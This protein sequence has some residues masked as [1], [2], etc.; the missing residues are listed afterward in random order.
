MKKIFTIALL[1]VSGLL[2]GQMGD[3]FFTK[4]TFLQLDSVTF[5]ETECLTMDSV[6][7][8]NVVLRDSFLI[9]KYYEFETLIYSGGFEIALNSVWTADFSDAEFV[10][11]SQFANNIFVCFLYCPK[12]NHIAKLVIANTLNQQCLIFTE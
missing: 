10:S 11:Y 6:L 12:H 9:V 1:F 2:Y 4:G 8:A 7:E 3:Y 5:A